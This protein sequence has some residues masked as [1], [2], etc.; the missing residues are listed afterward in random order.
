MYHFHWKSK[1]SILSNRRHYRWP[2]WFKFALHL[3]HQ[4]AQWQSVFCQPAMHGVVMIA[5]W[6]HLSSHWKKSF[7]FVLHCTTCGKCS[8]LLIH[9]ITLDLIVIKLFK[10]LTCITAWASEQVSS[11]PASNLKQNSRTS[12][13]QLT[14]L[15]LPS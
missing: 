10:E 12:T 1:K 8:R 2:T 4:S 5:V 15:T 13:D 3:E 6:Q 11:C 14:L 9:T 7:D